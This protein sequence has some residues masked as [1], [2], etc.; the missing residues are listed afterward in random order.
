MAL[1]D[2]ISRRA[3]RT[4][5]ARAVMPWGIA[6]G[7]YLLLILLAPRLLADPD[8]YSHIAMGRWIFDHHTVPTADPFS[9]TMR[10]T[11]WI[12]F[13]WLSEVVYAS[14]F[15]LGGWLAVTAVAAATAAAAF[16]QL[17]RLLLRH[18][19]PVPTLVAVVAAFV[20]TSPHI[21][22]RPHLL[23]LPLMVTWVGALLRAAEDKRAPSW[24]LLAVMTLWTNLHGSFSFGLAIIVPIACEAL[25]DAKPN[26]R[27]RVVQQWA[28]FA[29]GAL[30]AACLNPYGPEMILVTFRAIALGD[31]LATITEW[32]P[33]DFSHLGAFEII[34]LA[35]FG[36]AFY[37][38]VKLP[39]WR[40]VML[41]GVL[42]LSLSQQRHADLLGLLA[43]LFLARPL[44][45]QLRALA[46]APLGAQACKAAW[47]PAAVVVVFIAITGLGALHDVAPAAK[48]TP[49]KA[50]QS[51]DVAKAGP[52]F[53]DYDFGGYLDFAGIAPFIDGRG[54]M[55]G[56]AFISRYSRA[57]SLDNVADFLRLLDEY[58][59]GTTLL[60]P[61]TPAVSLLDRLPE[62]RRVYTDKVAVVHQRHA[63]AKK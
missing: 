56:G 34:M 6:G 47:F 32:R 61:S 44:A 16:G 63:P 48:I 43:P 36:L 9:S 62:W 49:A 41:L 50:L 40:I 59:I 58:R 1:A 4:F 29:F 52:I 17:T 25:W 22:A 14:A 39:L 51:I 23:A 45:E 24:W 7:I 57:L 13:E 19:Q 60:S 35:G 21:L 8:S 18:W 11:P 54:E 28:L 20:L 37:R 53:N 31:A 10:G 55:Y 46:A 15:A 30:S 33:Q 38:G 2:S 26:K 12:A 3:G 27:G 5:D 42:H